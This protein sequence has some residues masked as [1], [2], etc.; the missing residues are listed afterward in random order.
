MRDLG[1]QGAQRGRKV[2]TTAPGK[3][4]QRAPDLL[5]RDFTAPAPNRRWVADFTCSPTPSSSASPGMTCCAA[6]LGG[7]FPV[8]TTTT[9]RSGSLPSPPPDSWRTPRF[10]TCAH[11][12][13]HGACR[14]RTDLRGIPLAGP[15]VDHDHRRPIRPPGARGHRPGTRRARP[16]IRPAALMCPRCAPVPWRRRARCR[17]GV[18]GGGE[19]ACRPGSVRPL[20]RAGGHPSGTAVAGSLVR[21]TR[22]HR[23]G[24]PQSLAQARAAYSGMG[25]LDL[26]PGGV[27]RAAAVTCGAGGLLHHRFTLTV[28]VRTRAAAAVC[29]LWHC[30]AGHPGSVLPTTLPCGARTFLTGPRS[31]AT[32][33]PTHPLSHRIRRRAPRPG[34]STA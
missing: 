17:S 3:D 31:G 33:R 15:Q 34:L 20:A 19:P 14:G 28:A 23:A 9:A 4:G 11:L 1:L 27:Y 24:S 7:R 6:R 5:G 13:Q 2:R 18:Y 22:E 8:A 29:F 10:T 16:R 21:S 12:R 26:A 32:A 30:P 25:P